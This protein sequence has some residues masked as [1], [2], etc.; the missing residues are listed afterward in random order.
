MARCCQGRMGNG[1]R[2]VSQH[3]MWERD[4]EIAEFEGNV[5][6]LIILLSN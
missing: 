1:E 2:C 4:R 6:F 3:S 5:R